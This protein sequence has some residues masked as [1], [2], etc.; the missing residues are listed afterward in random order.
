MC[1][2]MLFSIVNSVVRFLHL[3]LDDSINAE[4]RLKFGKDIDYCEYGNRSDLVE[5]LPEGKFY[6]WTFMR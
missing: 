4:G 2:Q 1:R 5:K 6:P 3:F